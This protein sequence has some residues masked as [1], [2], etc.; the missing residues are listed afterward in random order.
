VTFLPV[1]L[2]V[3]VMHA[4]IACVPTCQELSIGALSIGRIVYQTTVLDV[5]LFDTVARRALVHSST[6]VSTAGSTRFTWQHLD[7]IWTAPFLCI[8]PCII[9]YAACQP[10]SHALGSPVQGCC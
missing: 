2:F 6:Y 4:F 9:C 7:D 3:S 5:D 1:L 8:P 10:Y